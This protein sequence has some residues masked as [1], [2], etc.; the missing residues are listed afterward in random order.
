MPFMLLLAVP[1]EI[2]A[3]TVFQHSAHDAPRRY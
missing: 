1:T 3:W 2:A